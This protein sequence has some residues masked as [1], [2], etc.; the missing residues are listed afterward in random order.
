MVNC[1]SFLGENRKRNTKG[2]S[3]ESHPQHIY[4]FMKKK[5]PDNPG[6]YGKPGGEEETPNGH[7]AHTGVAHSGV[8]KSCSR[9][10]WLQE[11]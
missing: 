3:E 6:G 1:S 8:R 2:Q 5:G 7:Q 11:V 4:Q 9:K 10:A